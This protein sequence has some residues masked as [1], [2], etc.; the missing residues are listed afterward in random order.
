MENCYTIIRIC[1]AHANVRAA[2]A[3]AA[4][5]FLC[6]VGRFGSCASL[7]RGVS[8]LFILAHKTLY[9]LFDS[10]QYAIIHHFDTQSFCGPHIGPTNQRSPTLPTLLSTEIRTCVCE[11]VSVTG[12]CISVRANSINVISIFPS[13]ARCVGTWHLSSFSV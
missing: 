9:T 6:V 13:F 8:V 7:W 10:N 2:S 3:A 5:F 4:L 12:A 1:R 11:R